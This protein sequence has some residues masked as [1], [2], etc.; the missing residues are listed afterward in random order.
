MVDRQ[1]LYSIGAEK[2]INKYNIK[3][4]DQLWKLFRIFYKSNPKVSMNICHYSSSTAIT[5]SIEPL[6]SI[7]DLLDNSASH[8]VYYINSNIKRSGNSAQLF[9]A[10]T[11]SEE[12]LIND[13]LKLKKYL[14]L[15]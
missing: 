1:Y 7:E 5:P 4:T 10:Y 15:I 12:K 2:V 6:G 9:F 11:D 14:I 13:L 8:I 3:S